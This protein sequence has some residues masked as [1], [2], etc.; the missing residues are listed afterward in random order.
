M[1]PN[2]TS[3]KRNT[4]HVKRE[5]WA[6][7]QHFWYSFVQLVKEITFAVA[8]HRRFPKTARILRKRA[9]EL[10]SCGSWSLFHNSL[11]LKHD[12]DGWVIAHEFLCL[13]VTSQ[14]KEPEDFL[15]K[16]QLFC[17]VVNESWAQFLVCYSHHGI[18]LWVLCPNLTDDPKEPTAW[19]PNYYDKDSFQAHFKDV[20][21][22][23]A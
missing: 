16:W 13:A 5:S 17:Y 18:V 7:H 11:Y 10:H 6:R 22:L 14:E 8:L 21:F 23:L 19:R 3:K 4:A 20:F 1:S 2:N 12:T 9:H 15:R